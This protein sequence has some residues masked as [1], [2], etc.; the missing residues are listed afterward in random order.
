MLLKQF[1]NCIFEFQ[2]IRSAS[3]KSKLTLWELRQASQS[4]NLSLSRIHAFIN[5]NVNTTLSPS[6]TI[7]EK[8]QCC[9]KILQNVLRQGIDSNEETKHSF[10]Y[11]EYNTTIA[12]ISPSKLAPTSSH[13]LYFCSGSP[14]SWEFSSEAYKSKYVSEPVEIEMQEPRYVTRGA[15]SITEEHSKKNLRTKT[16]HYNIRDPFRPSQGI[17]HHPKRKKILTRDAFP[18]KVTPPP[19][20][21]EK[22]LKALAPPP[23]PP[24]TRQAPPRVPA[25]D[26]KLDKKI[27]M[28]SPWWFYPVWNIQYVAMKAKARSCVHFPFL[29]LSLFLFSSD[30]TLNASN[31]STQNSRTGILSA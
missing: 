4:S 25:R 14:P 29:R 31:F 8:M 15:F 18:K 16:S 13:F 24:S 27:V 21:L 2:Y 28:I 22:E 11:N 6:T 23:P 5:T 30:S 20:A 19:S 26:G 17:S 12:I 9:A 7:F 1:W 3:I 10:Q